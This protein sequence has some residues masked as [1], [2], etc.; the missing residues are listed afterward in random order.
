[1]NFIHVLILSAV[2]GFTEFLPISSTGHMI[3]VSKLLGIAETDFVKTFEIVIQLGAILAIVVLYFKKFLSSWNLIKKLMV[4]FIPTAIVGFTLY[5]LIKGVLLGSSSITL[6]AL[7]W[8]GIAL[9]GVE[10]FLKRKKIE[11]KETSKVTYKQALIIGTF[12][13]I[14][15]IPGVSRAAATIIGGRLT[16]LSRETATE[17]S[18]LLAVPTMIAATALD[19]FKSRDMITQGGVLTLFVGSVLSFFFAIIAV[20]FLVN[21]VKNHDFTI[22]G[23]YRIALSILFWIFVK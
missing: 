18:F 8:G 10:W 21:Y 5:P 20:K 23:V 14:S 15:V 6:N 17:F 12:Q 7:F 22:F 3:L 16:G 2:E 11:A 9:I 19:V 13:S 4:A 1:M